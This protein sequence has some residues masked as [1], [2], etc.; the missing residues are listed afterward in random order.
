MR[1]S[2]TGSR[3]GI[4]GLHLVVLFGEGKGLWPRWR[5]YVTG[6]WLA[7]LKT[8]TG[9]SCSLCFMF[10]IQGVSSHPPVTL[11]MPVTCCHVLLPLSSSPRNV[12]KINSLFLELFVCLSVLSGQRKSY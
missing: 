11:T 7:G 5:K 4:F 6:D 9:S 3:A 2:P 8:P 1:M 10:E 12:G